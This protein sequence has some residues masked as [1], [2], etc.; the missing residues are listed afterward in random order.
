MKCGW[1][2]T[3]PG[4]FLNMFPLCT[5]ETVTQMLW[6][7]S[8]KQAFLKLKMVT[9]NLTAFSSLILRI[10]LPCVSHLRDQSSICL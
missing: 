3:T 7:H 8:L 1:L 9:G 10:N 4:G 2:H 5:L 6:F